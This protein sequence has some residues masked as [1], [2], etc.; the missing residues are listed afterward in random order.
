[1]LKK[2]L[3]KLTGLAIVGMIVA[4]FVRFRHERAE[5]RGFFHRVLAH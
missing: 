4:R 2:T 3:P 5:K 1:M